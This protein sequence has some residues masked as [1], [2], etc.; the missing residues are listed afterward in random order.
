MTGLVLYAFIGNFIG[1]TVAFALNLYGARTAFKPWNYMFGAI[2]A[3]ALV[4]AVSYM[5]L[6]TGHWSIPVWSKYVR[7]LGLVAWPLAWWTPVLVFTHRMNHY[8]QRLIER[9]VV[10]VTAAFDATETPAGAGVDVDGA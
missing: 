1:S 7:F 8:E 4:F 10:A 6:I 5:W 3:L 9:T 2:A